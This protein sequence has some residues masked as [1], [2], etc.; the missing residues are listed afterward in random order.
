MN[1]LIYIFLLGALILSCDKDDPI[2]VNPFDQYQGNWGGSYTGGDNGTWMAAIDT[3]GNVSGSASSNVFN[4]TYI[5]EGTVSETGVFTATVG[6]ATS[7]AIF[8]G[9]IDGNNVT[10]TW[11]NSSAMLSGEW[12]GTK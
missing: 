7:G 12:R 2:D 1:K 9:N 8:T 3:E 4:Q 6:T 10:G 11:S 5:L